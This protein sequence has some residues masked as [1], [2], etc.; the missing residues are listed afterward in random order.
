LEVDD[1]GRG[2]PAGRGPIPDSRAHGAK[3][4]AA[5]PTRRQAARTA[6]ACSSPRCC[7]WH[8]LGKSPEPQAKQPNEQ[9]RPS[10][11]ATRSLAA[12]ACW[13][14]TCGTTRASR[15]CSPGS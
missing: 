4:S 2:R 6:R 7:Q 11:S 12:R 10:R 5:L 8:G 14:A 9:L 1:I 3:L 15:I 13:P